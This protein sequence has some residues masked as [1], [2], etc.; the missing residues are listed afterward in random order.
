MPF[1]SVVNPEISP[2][3]PLF[4]VLKHMPLNAFFLFCLLIGT[5][6]DQANAAVD[7][8][9]LKAIQPGTI[10]IIGETHHQK[11][12]IRLF[13]GLVANYLQQNRCLT[14][15]LEIASN[16]QPVID[17]VT[18]NRATASDIK[19]PSMIDHPP[20]RKMMDDLAARKAKGACLKLLVIDTGEDINM[21]RDAWMALKLADH[22]GKTPILILLGGLH[23]MKKIDWNLSMT[24]GKRFVS[25]ILSKQGFRVRT[26]PQAPGQ[27]KNA[28]LGKGSKIDLSRQTQPR[29]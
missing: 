20:F 1:F 11:E 2:V 10:T 9:I 26:F 12:S 17:L 23:T 7:E 5:I 25:E 15:A 4:Q 28:L 14:V 13:Q 24:K 6:T 27:L 18:Q 8:P 3:L 21:S 22:I 19:I 16:Q 29:H